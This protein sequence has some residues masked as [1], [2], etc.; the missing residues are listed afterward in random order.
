MWTITN[1]KKYRNLRD[2][3][4]VREKARERK[5][6][7]RS[8]AVTQCHTPSHTITQSH[9]IAEAEA[10]A[11][12]PANAAG[13]DEE[14]GDPPKRQLQEFENESELD[15]FIDAFLDKHNQ[16]AFEYEG[17]SSKYIH[18]RR[19]KDLRN[20]SFPND[21][22]RVEQLEKMAQIVLPTGASPELFCIFCL[23]KWHNWNNS[24]LPPELKSRAGIGFAS[25]EKIIKNG[26]RLA[27]TFI[28][29][30]HGGYTPQY[31]PM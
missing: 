1:Y 2:P 3:D 17:A 21:Q 7:Q 31:Y 27:K 13:E 23:E 6:R 12:S 18:T 26:A 11:K 22:D 15:S 10:E 5:Q 30:P 9:D 8:R 19:M 24:K 14:W 25:I 20:S 16:L 29:I 4:E 28:N